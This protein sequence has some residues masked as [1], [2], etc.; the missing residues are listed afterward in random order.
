MLINN[1]VSFLGKE[2]KVNGKNE[3]EMSFR[4]RARL[5]SVNSTVAAHPFDTGPYENC[6]KRNGTLIKGRTLH[7]CVL[8]M[9]VFFYGV[10]CGGTPLRQNSVESEIPA[11]FQSLWT[12]LDSSRTNKTSLKTSFVDLSGDILWCKAQCGH[13]KCVT[14][15][16]LRFTINISYLDWFVSLE[17]GE[18]V[19]QN[20]II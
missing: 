11:R 3:W 15:C 19:T 18:N 14:F 12:I 7:F 6:F 2:W 1:I 17:K 8:T 4:K 10:V 20:Y 9:Q 5:S 13:D 16:L